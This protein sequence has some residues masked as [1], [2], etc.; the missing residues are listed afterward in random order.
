MT[1]SE[2]YRL[3][4][5]DWPA[6]E[7]DEATFARLLGAHDAED[8]SNRRGGDLYLAL[9]CADGNDRAIAELERS[10]MPAAIAA[11][12]RMRGSVAS[13]DE[14]AQVVRTHVLVATGDGAPRIAGYAG[15]GSLKSW[16]TAIAVRR[17]LNALRDNKREV[18]LGDEEVMD[19]IAAKAPTPEFAILKESYRDKFRAGFSDALASL[20]AKEK[21]LLRHRFVDGLNVTD[22]AKLHDV[23]RAT[24]HRW[25][26]DAQT[27]VAERTEQILCKELA[28]SAAE[29]ASIRRL[30]RS[31]LEVSLERL[32]KD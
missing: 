28:V 13:A 5:K 20:G 32:L 25:L 16:L 21:T 10:F 17:Y 6:V 15:T 19:A 1:P 23:H 30:V 31:Q 27:A 29:L 24:L 14:I 22:L 26:A 12:R 7:L 9:A 11:V 3:G 2:L 4:Q 8:L 18:L